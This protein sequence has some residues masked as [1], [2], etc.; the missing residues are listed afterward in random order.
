MNID[1][2]NAV[3]NAGIESALGAHKKPKRKSNKVLP[4]K[5]VL[6]L[7]LDPGVLSRLNAWAKER[8]MSRSATVSFAVSLLPMGNLK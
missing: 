5:R 1:T 2:K 6:A 3:N 4:K 8:G 7:S